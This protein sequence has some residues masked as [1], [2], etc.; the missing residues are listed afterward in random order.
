MICKKSN[1]DPKINDINYEFH[2]NSPN[3]ICDEDVSETKFTS[4]HP[5]AALN[6]LSGSIGDYAQQSTHDVATKLLKDFDGSSTRRPRS[7]N[8]DEIVPTS[9][10]K[11]DPKH[12]PTATAE[13]R[14]NNNPNADIQDI[15][16]GIVKLLNGNVNVHANTQFPPP[17]TRRFATRINNR[18]PP[19]ISDFPVILPG[20]DEKFSSIPQKTTPYPTGIRKPPTVP[21]PFD[22]PPDKPLRN[23]HPIVMH[24]KPLP[25]NR[26]PWHGSRTRPPI[27]I[28]NT[29][30]LQLPTRVSMNLPPQLSQ[31]LRPPSKT[32]NPMTAYTTRIPEVNKM[33][34]V[35]PNDKPVPN[36]MEQIVTK[37]SNKP[38]P[39]P[40]ETTQKPDIPK[41]T[42]KMPTTT[43]MPVEET[44]KELP[45]ELPVMVQSSTAALPA[46]EIP[47]EPFVAAPAPAPFS[48]A[49]H[50]PST[51]EQSK[52]T[53]EL[54]PS[55]VQKTQET[56]VEIKTIE[57]VHTS[58]KST[59]EP[60]RV[61]KPSQQIE[62]SDFKSFYARP[63]IV[64]DDT[65]YK[66]GAPGV[67][68]PSTQNTFHHIHR[69]PSVQSSASLSNIYAEI[70]DVT[71]SAIQGQPHHNKVVDLIEIGH[72]GD[73]S[74]VIQTK[75]YNADG[76][77]IIVSAS[78]D[79]SFVSIDG[80]RTYINLFGET[81]ETEHVK[82]PLKTQN[83]QRVYASKTVNCILLTF[84][85]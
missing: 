7:E 43:P 45:E 57:P 16:T 9:I 21:Y 24:N 64:L 59:I 47:T 70:F 13:E 41:K 22:L 76:N 42:T 51:T 63:G 26:P 58:V 52:A 15:I 17:S 30:R 60:S 11:F 3:E 33:P 65:D 80:K 56:S 25:S 50:P 12:S 34:D 68:E 78:D 32:A 1:K 31:D 54:T 20:I 49:P 77:D 62:S 35:Y 46:V 85:F 5:S 72:H 18:G 75:L 19:R 69:T 66:P 29:N 74:D 37:A 81:V 40:K 73:A 27:Q 14:Q 83:D 53:P 84:F 48:H 10:L 6:S 28:T 38:E 67:L 36:L 61:L 4:I 44:T 71:L 79:N 8:T 55:S 2:A 39:P 23:E 82:K